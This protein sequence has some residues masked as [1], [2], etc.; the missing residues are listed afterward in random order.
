MSTR[1]RSCRT[2]TRAIQCLGKRAI[3]CLCFTQAEEVWK[4]SHT[5]RPSLDEVSKRLAE[6][7]QPSRAVR[8]SEPDNLLQAIEVERCAAAHSSVLPPPPPPRRCGF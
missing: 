1:R 3:T 5:F 4:R 6:L 7:S 2:D 8:F